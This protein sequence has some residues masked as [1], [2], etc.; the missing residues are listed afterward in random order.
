[1]RR[2]NDEHVGPFDELLEN[3]LSVRRLQIERYAALVAVGQMPRISILRLRLRRKF[4][5]MSPEIAVRR[6]HFDDVGAEVRQDHGGAW[7][8]NEAREVHHFESGKNVVA[9]QWSSPESVD[10]VRSPSLEPGCALF[11]EGGRALLLV[12]R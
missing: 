12:L 8:R 1:M 10:R 6:F 4:V 7:S 3:V 2:I 11:E 5:C 9:C